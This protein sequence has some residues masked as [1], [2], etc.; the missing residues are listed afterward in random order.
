MNTGGTSIVNKTSTALLCCWSCPFCFVAYWCPCATPAS[1]HIE[2][3]NSA[4]NQTTS[5]T[6]YML[7]AR[8]YMSSRPDRGRAHSARRHVTHR[9]A[10]GRA[11]GKRLPSRT[12]RPMTV[13]TVGRPARPLTPFVA[14]KAWRPLDTNSVIPKTSR[15]YSRWAEAI[16]KPAGS[17][18]YTH[19]GHRHMPS[20]Q[21]HATGRIHGWRES[22]GKLRSYI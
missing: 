8:R 5:D 7:G 17:W 1:F 19:S 10:S 2:P 12:A 6:G 22:V 9:Q 13:F 14:K 18:S 20:R 21:T 16:N 3:I 4:K 15:L 11:H